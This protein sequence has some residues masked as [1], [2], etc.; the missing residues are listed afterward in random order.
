[1]T[2][3]TTYLVYGNLPISIAAAANNIKLDFAAGSASIVSGTMGGEFTFVLANGTSLVVPL[4][5]LN[6]AIS[7]GST[8]AWV[9]GS[10]QFVCQVANGGTLQLEFAQA[11]AAANNTT[12]S[13]GAYLCAMPLD[14]VINQ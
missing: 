12:I 9:N 4:T 10:F 5:A 6:T 1:M 13:A 2:G 11:A 14:H 7:G 8:N 3:N